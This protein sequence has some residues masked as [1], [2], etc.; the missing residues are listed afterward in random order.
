MKKFSK[1]KLHLPKIDGITLRWLINII[2]V[3]VVFF[4]IVFIISA[5]SIKNTYYSNVESI[6]NSGASSTAVSYFS[7]NLD[8]GNTLEQ[9]AAEYIDSYSYKEKTT[10][11]IIDIDG[12]VVVSSSG[13]AIEKQDMP[14]YTQALENDNNKA[15]YIGKISNGEKVMAVCRIIKD[16]NGD[17]V[18]AIRVL[19]SLEQIDRQV[20]TLIFLVLAA[21]IIVFALI[22]F[23]NLFFIRSI[24]FPVQEI[25]ETTK[26][27]SQGDYSVRIEKKYD[28]E[29]GNLCDSI[30]TMA[31]EISTTDKMKNDFISTISHELRTPLTSIKGWGETLMLGTDDSV[32]ELTRKG[33]QVI[34]KEAGRLEG[35]V[36][37]LLDFSRL[38]SG[39]MNLRLAKTDLFAELDE[40]VFTFRERALRDGIEV[41]YSIPEVPA[42]ANADANRLKQ[43]F[44][45]ILD[46]ALKYS[47]S[48]SKI[49]V[50]AEFTKLDNQNFVKIAIADQGCG[51]SKEDLP[52][53]KEKFYKANVSVRGS[54][55]GL[56][57]TNEIVNL[58]HGKL[59]IDSQEGK[60]TLV[61]IYLPVENSPTKNELNDMKQNETVQDAEIN[62]GVEINK[63]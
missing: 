14:D 27:I 11:W 34:V 2:G 28:D 35:F 62:E 53:V 21:L 37:E 17:N 29:I 50:K 63:N 49:F 9:S 1:E 40:T 16:S 13:F 42:I 52:H 6:L 58:H 26:K 8:A 44:M 20:T 12:N 61:T 55:I 22:I 25:T 43:V 59:E 19:S 51:I 4:I 57:V 23:S 33:L 10:T 41:K 54:G 39:R 36:E 15:K 18:G 31:E 60:G 7:A 56:A 47:R 38:Q 32:D 46:N 48:P 24:I 30:N 5:F 3:I 45:N